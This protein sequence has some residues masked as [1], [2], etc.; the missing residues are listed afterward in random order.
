MAKKIS[1]RW[2]V[3]SCESVMIPECDNIE[4]L[5]IGLIDEV[6]EVCGAIKKFI[7]GDYGEDELRKRVS[8]E[9]GDVMWYVAMIGERVCD[10]TVF[11][12]SV[13]SLGEKTINLNNKELLNHTMVLT[14]TMYKLNENSNFHHLVNAITVASCFCDWLGVDISDSCR[15]VV[16]KLLDRQEAGTIKGDGEGVYRDE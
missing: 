7:R 4:Y 15:S 8:S 14:D 5:V 1:W 9:I 6:G 13:S 2:F 16:V 12:E 3:D 11:V 10:N